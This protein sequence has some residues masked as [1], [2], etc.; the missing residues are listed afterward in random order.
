MKSLSADYLTNLLARS[1]IRD[2]LEKAV[3][4][5]ALETIVRFDAAW[6]GP[7]LPSFEPARPGSDVS[8]FGAQ[9]GGPDLPALEAAGLST[10][11][12]AATPPLDI[13]GALLRA[14]ISYN[15]HLDALNPD[16]RTRAW[17]LRQ[18]VLVCASGA[19]HLRLLN[20]ERQRLLNS[21]DATLALPSLLGEY[22]ADDRAML[23]TPNAELE[24]LADTYLREFLRGRSV[25]DALLANH[26]RAIT[27]AREELEGVM[28][29]SPSVPSLAEC[30]RRAGLAEILIPL[31]ILIGVDP[32]KAPKSV[33]DRFVGRA[34]E[35]LILRSVVDELASHSVLESASRGFHRVIRSKPRLL[36][37]VARGGLGKTA[38]VA[39][40]LYDHATLSRQQFP[41][42]YLDF[43]RS[44]VQPRGPGLML[45]EICRQLS[46][47]YPNAE[48]A[49]H[50]LSEQMR[51]SLMGRATGD[52]RQ[53]C[54]T[55]R[56]IIRT[57][58]R[59]NGAA[60]F[61]LV[62]DTLEIVESD[63]AAT[64]GVVILLRTLGA[65]SEDPFLEFCVVAAGRSGV[66]QLSVGDAF[67]VTPLKLQPLSV[68]DARGMVEQ[69]GKDLLPNEW[70][71]SWSRRI[72]GRKKDPDSRREPLSL[73]VAV[74][75]VRDTK[76]DMRATVVD[77]IVRLGESADDKFVA[78]LYERRIL[79]HVRDERARKLAW[80]G[81]VARNVTRHMAR[82]VLAPVCGLDASEAEVA[83][84]LLS[85]ETWLVEG[86][87]GGDSIRHRRELR[88]RTLPLM[89]RRDPER[90]NRVVEALIV[91]YADRDPVEH[92]YYVLLRG[93]K[94]EIYSDRSLHGY[95]PEFVVDIQDFETGSPAWNLIQAKFG[96]RSLEFDHMSQL[97]DDLLWEHLGRTGSGL[98]GIND[99]RIEPRV[100]LLAERDRPASSDDVG[101]QS[102]WQAIQIKC[103]FWSRLDPA[104]LVIPSAQFDL[105]QFA[106][107]VAQLSLAGERPPAYWTQRYPA[108]I[109]SLYSSRGNDNWHALT[110]SLI[111]AGLYDPTLFAH[112]EWR[113]GDSL[114]GA[115]GQGRMREC[116]LR[117]L[118]QVGFETQGTALTI[119]AKAEK[120]RILGGISFA[121]YAILVHWA[122][123]SGSRGRGASDKFR[124]L[125]TE[126]RDAIE[127]GSMAEVPRQILKER[128]VIA[129]ATTLLSA[130][131]TWG[132]RS[133][134]QRFARQY[135]SVRQPEWIVPFAYLLN[136]CLPQTWQQ[137]VGQE[138]SSDRYD[139]GRQGFFGQ[140]TSTLR[141]SRIPADL[142]EYLMLADRA[143]DFDTVV[144]RLCELIDANRN[145]DIQSLDKIRRQARTKMVN[146]EMVVPGHTRN[147]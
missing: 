110:Q 129:E 111:T 2:Q 71:E 11:A 108:L 50:Q 69:L 76:P 59:L 81:L 13:S 66:D 125:A 51:Q 126:H 34:E 43:D 109:D 35:L 27:A 65:D 17:L 92:V 128:D 124:A 107:Y 90:F 75:M 22:E 49:L 56:S 94:E 115:S 98:R 141:R 134:I 123:G 112:I 146:V 57:A 67:E 16:V 37:L 26:R 102:A 82:E 72:A 21:V 83:F 93:D 60:T 40:F 64:E 120:D 44:D 86:Q 84:D 63:L 89:R 15:Y 103:G 29:I 131:A 25:S 101:Q 32:A 39:K 3:G 52:L 97:P 100:Q 87:P 5:T 135:C 61:L 143:G 105:T 117:F 8:E 138:V 24:K 1:D 132:D 99:R 137:V 130:I 7:N 42:A 47:Q 4:K 77:D 18:S 80:P 91:Y 79:D 45:L 20:A 74:E 140:I 119:W 73:R 144:R 127:R 28:N 36:S 113:L 31:G 147:G 58:L 48:Q 145:V 12:D 116:S 88:A 54:K 122:G 6:T 41:F 68:D 121:E 78:A 14:A 19:K 142:I 10:P 114:A 38:L 118:L 23:S 46:F 70:V 96:K 85:R 30:R 136:A 9:K 62:L 55:F 53:W 104:A 106:F 95:L 133:R 33:G 139:P